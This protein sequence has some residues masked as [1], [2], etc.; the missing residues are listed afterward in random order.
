MENKFEN[1]T[2]EQ[3]WKLFPIFLTKH[4]PDWADWYKEEEK[5]LRN[6]LGT[7]DALRIS[8]IGSTAIDKLW[9][10]PI[11]DILIET[12]D[13]T[14]LERVCETLIKAGYILMAKTSDRYSFNKGY[15][16]KGLDDKVYHIHLRLKGDNDGSVGHRKPH[17]NTV[18]Q[19]HLRPRR[20]HGGKDGF[21]RH[22]HDYS[23]TALQRQSHH[24]AYRIKNTHQK[25]RIFSFTW[26]YCVIKLINRDFTYNT[27]Y[28][29]LLVYY[30]PLRV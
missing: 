7:N 28:T 13:K 9:A 1:M 20:L 3:L 4:N 16:P 2:K 5:T 10:K 11:I 19:I 14:A 15:T 8:H 22:G 12:P 29:N 24:I 18:A 21:R 23:N 25:V 26:L 17:T 27:I 30:N 6:L